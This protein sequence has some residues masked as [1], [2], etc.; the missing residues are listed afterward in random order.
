MDDDPAPRSRLALIGQQ[1]GFFL[2]PLFVSRKGHMT[3]FQ[4]MRQEGGRGGGKGRCWAAHGKASVSPNEPGKR[5]ISLVLWLSLCLERG[6]WAATTN[7]LFGRN[8]CMEED[9]QREER[10]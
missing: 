10:V 2:L 3:Q 8:P 1:N 4:L 6:E 5:E 7:W 9:A